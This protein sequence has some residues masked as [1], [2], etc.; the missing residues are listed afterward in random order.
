[1]PQTVSFHTLGCKLNFSETTTLERQ[2][3][4]AGYE[5]VPFNAGADIYI[6]NTCSVTENADKKCRKVVRSALNKN[7]EA[8]VALV[9]CYAQLKPRAIAELEGV[10][11]VLGAADKF[12]LLER[13]ESFTKRSEP[14]VHHCAVEAVEA[15]VPS[16][17]EAERTRAF[18][19][20]QDGCD[21]NCSFCTIPQARGRS[22]SPSLAEAVQYADHLAGQGAREIVLTGINLGDYG[23]GQDA[24]CLDLLRRLDAEVQPSVER[25]RISSIEPNLLN[26]AIIAHVAA[27]KRF[28]PH[29]HMPLQSGSN[30]ILR[31]MRRRY[32]REHYAER[33]EQIKAAMPDACIG[34]DVITGF[35]GETEAQFL[36]TY[37]FLNALPVAYLHVFP[38]SARANTPAEQMAGQL[39]WQLREERSQMLRNLSLKKR[40]AFNSS[41]S[42]QTRPV[43]YEMGNYNGKLYGYTDNYIKVEQPYQAALKHSIVPTR[44]GEPLD[45]QKM[46]GEIVTPAAIAR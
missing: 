45:H 26:D 34:V 15:F 6:I 12:R 14:E 9:G 16:F 19:K 1:M 20:L 39:P 29:L 18:L 7:P 10:D 43:L 22:R 41:F 23:K 30:A 21:Y 24:N 46:S 2:F 33:V 4:S 44:L 36:E 3:R 8:F 13:I 37:E 35:P 27:S 11:A 25:F 42:G 40:R 28:M 31:K 38:F 5:P 17:S 32:K